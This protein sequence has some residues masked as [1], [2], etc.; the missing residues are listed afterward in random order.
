[1]LILTRRS[2]SALPSGTKSR[3]TWWKSGGN[4][5]AWESKP[6][7]TPPSTGRGVPEDLGGKPFAA[8]VPPDDF[9]RMFIEGVRLQ[10]ENPHPPLRSSG[11]RRKSGDPSPL[12]LIGFPGQKRYVLL[13]HKKDRPL[14]GS[15]RWTR[16]TCLCADRPPAIKPDLNTRSAPRIGRPWT[17]DESCEGL[18]TLVIVNITP[19]DPLKITANTAGSG[20]DKPPEEARQ[21]GRPAPISLLDRVPIP[22]VK[23]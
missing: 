3:Y 6:Q 21:A 10:I 20:G 12:G 13:E 2:V 9:D 1:M 18:Q 14:S 4:R 22:T 5:C 15:R 16:R 23:K 11:D 8:R 7:P 17:S 19:G